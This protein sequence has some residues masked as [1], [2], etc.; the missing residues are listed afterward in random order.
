MALLLDIV[1]K[2]LVGKRILHNWAVD[3][4]Y[5]AL[6]WNGKCE[7]YLPQKQ[8]KPGRYCSCYWGQDQAYD[9]DGTDWDVTVPQLAADYISGDLEILP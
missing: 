9:E 6:K 8:C 3:D 7:E 1:E 2:R 4:Y 5:A